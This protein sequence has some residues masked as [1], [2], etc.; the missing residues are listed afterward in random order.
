MLDLAHE[1]GSLTFIDEVHAVGLYGDNGAGIG[2]RDD[3]LSK[4]DIISGT[5]G[6]RSLHSHNRYNC[7]K[8]R[9]LRQS[10]RQYR[11]L[12][13]RESDHYGFRSKLRFGIYLYN[14]DATDG[15]SQCH[16]SDRGSSLPE[17]NV[18]GSGSVRFQIS[19]SEE[20]RQLRRKQQ[21]NVRELRSKLLDAGLPVMIAP[22]HIIPIHV[23]QTHRSVFV[24][25][26]SCCTS[27]RRCS[28]RWSPL[29]SSTR[30]VFDLH[31][32]DQL[33]D[34]CTWHRA[35]THR[36]DPVSQQCDDR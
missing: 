31:S 26:L 22:S 7:F 9:F 25:D 33:S 21:R 16:S 18:S 5:L 3:V 15:L 30:T 28:T 36:P 20:G 13:R 1:Y 14:I 8:L 10:I 32:I 2:E 4:M 17:G 35:F 27:G 19:M 29:Q 6:Q 34:C 24:I 23:S 12:H 11:W